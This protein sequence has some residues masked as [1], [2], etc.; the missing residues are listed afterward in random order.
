M[1]VNVSLLQL[2]RPKNLALPSQ[3]RSSEVEGLGYST[4]LFHNRFGR[5]QN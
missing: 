4:L 2:I 3:R 1:Y 5:L